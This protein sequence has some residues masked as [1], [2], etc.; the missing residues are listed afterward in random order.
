MRR[1]PAR[2]ALALATSALALSAQA[3]VHRVT[4]V[5]NAGQRADQAADRA[6]L[7]ID[8]GAAPGDPGPEEPPPDPA[9]RPWTDPR[10]TETDGPTDAEWH[11]CVPAWRPALWAPADPVEQ[12][13]LDAGVDWVWAAGCREAGPPEDDEGAGASR[14]DTRWADGSYDHGVRTT[15]GDAS[16]DV[17]WIGVLDE[18]NEAVAGL[19]ADDHFALMDNL[20]DQLHEDPFLVYDPSDSAYSSFEG[21]YITWDYTWVEMSDWLARSSGVHLY[22]HSLAC[23]LSSEANHLGLPA[24]YVT[25]AYN[26]QTHLT[27]AAGTEDWQRWSFNSHGVVTVDGGEHI[28]DAAVDYDGDEDPDSEPVTAV[29]AK[30]TPF[31]E[32]LELLT[33]DEIGQ[34]NG[35]T[36]FVY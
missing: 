14:Y 21:S 32:Y 18:V 4:L 35:G 11:D 20:R 8:A 28:W 12:G 7:V 33:A 27:R 24:E 3:D 23:V 30:G 26:F 15:C 16:A 5:S 13:L 29:S 22:C 19:P 2:M 6:Y 9:G 31:D 25:L 10:Y 36:C 1:A 17:A 34:V